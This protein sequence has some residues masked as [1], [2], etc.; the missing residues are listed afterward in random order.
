MEVMMQQCFSF[1]NKKRYNL[2]RLEAIRL[3]IRYKSFL[4]YKKQII[5]NNI[6]DGVGACFLFILFYFFIL[7]I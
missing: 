3:N 4:S 7:F 1:G 5:K 2:T 6:K